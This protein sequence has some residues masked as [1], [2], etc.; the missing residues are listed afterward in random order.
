MGATTSCLSTTV[1]SQGSVDAFIHAASTFKVTLPHRG[2]LLC[3][4][5]LEVYVSRPCSGIVVLSEEIENIQ[6]YDQAISA[7]Q[8]TRRDLDSCFNGFEKSA[9]YPALRLCIDGEHVAV[10]LRNWYLKEQGSETISGTN[11]QNA[12]GVEGL[13]VRARKASG[14]AAFS[15]SSSSRSALEPW[16]AVRGRWTDFGVWRS[17]LIAEC[18]AVLSA[19]LCANVWAL[20]LDYAF[21]Q[22]P[23]DDNDDA[24]STCSLT[25]RKGISIDKMA[26]NK[27]SIPICFGE[28]RTVEKCQLPICYNH[29]GHI[30]VDRYGRVLWALPSRLRR[31]SLCLPNRCC[32]AVEHLIESTFN[33]Y[34]ATRMWCNV[35]THYV[36]EMGSTKKYLW[37]MDW[38]FF[39]WH[40]PEVANFRAQVTWKGLWIPL[41][42]LER[43]TASWLEIDLGTTKKPSSSG[44]VH[45]DVLGTHADGIDLCLHDEEKN[46][47]DNSRYALNSRNSTFSLNRVSQKHS[48]RTSYLCILYHAY[49]RTFKLER[50]VNPLPTWTASRE[51]FLRYSRPKA[52]LNHSAIFWK[53]CYT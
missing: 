29:E 53:Q 49:D 27:S 12:L 46:M 10:L 8:F 52:G 35:F 41:A 50:I 21:C 23:Y 30:I 48:L 39:C 32:S 40:F 11:V 43:V 45:F 19:P 5:Q 24:R 22:N 25:Y 20:V 18:S 9:V 2:I 4:L 47:S 37:L 44:E 42:Y 17:R 36:M 31:I 6:N 15:P 51:T 26:N 3:G 14:V 33:G 13:A 34:T 28:F 1:R 38:K 7:A 16:V